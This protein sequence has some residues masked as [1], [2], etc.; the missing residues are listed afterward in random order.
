MPSQQFRET[1]W[2]WTKTILS[3][4][5]LSLLLRTF[6]VEARWIPSESMVP[7]FQVGDRLLVEKL[8]RKVGE[9][10]RGEIIVFDPPPA[11]GLNE[12]LIKRIIGLPGDVI[13]VQNGIVYL[14]GVAQDEAYTLEKAK[15]NFG[16]YTVPANDLFV[17][18]DN[19]NNSFDSRY[20]GS[21][22]Q[23]MVIGKAFFKFYPLQEIGLIKH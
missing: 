23:T 18:G 10:H 7:T 3:A 14:N 4:V 20:W 1:V 17:M 19:R 11:S 5:I 13:R 22:P 8:T 2:D 21:V 15:Q 16:P 12:P 9:F 6:V